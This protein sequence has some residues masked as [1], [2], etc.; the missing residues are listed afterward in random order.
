MTHQLICCTLNLTEVSL[1]C[2]IRL[3]QGENL[4]ENQR[5]LLQITERFFHAIIGS[6]S[7]FP[8]Q[9]RSVCHCLYQVL[10][11]FLYQ[12]LVYC[13]YQVVLYLLYQVLLLLLSLA[14]LVPDLFGASKATVFLTCCSRTG[15]NRTEHQSVCTTIQ[16]LLLTLKLKLNQA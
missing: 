4:E 6:S 3:E 15:L 10:F 8:P 16:K 2:L 12:V 5:N 1:F 14:P 11:Y 7:E 13:L 9:L